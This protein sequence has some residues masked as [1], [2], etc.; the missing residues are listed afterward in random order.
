MSKGALLLSSGKHVSRL[1]T[2][3]AAIPSPGGQGAP[4]PWQ[5]TWSRSRSAPREGIASLPWPLASEW[6]WFQRIR[7]GHPARWASPVRRRYGD[8]RNRL[9]PS[10]VAASKDPAS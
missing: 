1:P 2:G 8:P 9:P 5:R 10:C 7:P 4:S 6:A 3:S